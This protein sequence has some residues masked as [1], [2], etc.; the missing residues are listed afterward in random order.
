MEQKKILALNIRNTTQNGNAYNILSTL[1]IIFQ[2]K[3]VLF[4][5]TG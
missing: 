2:V 5:K 4:T 1:F 3:S